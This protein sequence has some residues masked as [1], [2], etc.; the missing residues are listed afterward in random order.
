MAPGVREPAAREAQRGTGK[1]GDAGTEPMAEKA[2]GASGKPHWGQTSCGRGGCTWIKVWFFPH[3]FSLLYSAGEELDRLNS[4]P[5]SNR[6]ETSDTLEKIPQPG[7]YRIQI[8]QGWADTEAPK[9]RA[10]AS[11]KGQ[12]SQGGGVRWGFSFGSSF[13]M[14]GILALQK[15]E[16]L[17]HSQGPSELL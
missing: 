9:A 13:K 12:P 17:H 14:G 1:P 8:G 11:G 3:F 15:E 2:V 4:W 7:R 5:G 16:R 10:F 6:G